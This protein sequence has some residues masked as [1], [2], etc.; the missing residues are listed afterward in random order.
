MIYLFLSYSSKTSQKVS[1]SD[2]NTD[3]TQQSVNAHKDTLQYAEELF[4][5]LWDTEKSK[6]LM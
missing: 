3:T 4:C 5:F 6:V 2:F 1:D